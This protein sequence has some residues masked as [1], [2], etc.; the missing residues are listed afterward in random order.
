MVET[1]TIDIHLSIEINNGG[2]IADVNF[3]N[4][5]SSIIYLDSWTICEDSV[6]RS[7]I[8]SIVD[9]NN[10][11]A[12]YLGPIINRKV[13]SEDFIALDPGESI[14]S[15]IIINKDYELV[16]GHT[17]KIRFCASNPTFVDKQSRLDLLSNEVEITY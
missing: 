10:K 2:V 13:L 1:K 17:Y 8:F 5:T 3:I 15:K 12:F 7:N 4:N 6:V 9:E 11:H 16:K 14:K